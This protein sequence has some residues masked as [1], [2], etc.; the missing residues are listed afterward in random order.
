MGESKLKK[1][2]QS[3]RKNEIGI[4]RKEANMQSIMKLLE[5]KKNDFQE[6]S[7][8]VTELKQAAEDEQRTKKKLLENYNR[9]KNELE[10]KEGVLTQL[11]E[12]IQHNK[13]NNTGC[14]KL[15]DTESQNR[16]KELARQL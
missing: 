1:I 12:D 8:L 3:L 11:R 5:E 6:N 15:N 4:K 16:L 10:M 13:E 7:D 14:F 2:V 9:M